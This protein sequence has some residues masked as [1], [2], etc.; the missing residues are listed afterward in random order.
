[1]LQGFLDG[2]SL[3]GSLFLKP[4][5]LKLMALLLLGML[6]IRVPVRGFIPLLV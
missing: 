2:C 5:L 4:A 1:M 6:L 3:M